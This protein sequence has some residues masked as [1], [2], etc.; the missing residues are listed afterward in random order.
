MQTWLANIKLMQTLL[1]FLANIAA[2][3]DNA[4]VFLANI[5]VYATK[6]ALC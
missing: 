6:A 4:V 3:A 2:R 1:L 5:A